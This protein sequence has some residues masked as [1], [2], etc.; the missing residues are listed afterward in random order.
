MFALAISEEPFAFCH[1]C[2]CCNHA[3][4][5]ACGPF[6]RCTAATSNSYKSHYIIT[7]RFSLRTAL[8][9]RASY[10][11]LKLLGRP[12]RAG[13][14]S[15]RKSRLPAR[16]PVIGQSVSPWTVN[17]VLSCAPRIQRSSPQRAEC[18]ATRRA[19][20]QQTHG[21]R[22]GLNW[23]LANGQDAE[24]IQ[25][26]DSKIICVVI[27]PFLF[28]LCIFFNIRSLFERP[29]FICCFVLWYF[30]VLILLQGSKDKKKF[31]DTTEKSRDQD[32]FFFVF[33]LHTCRSVGLLLQTFIHWVNLTQVYVNV[34]VK[35]EYQGFVGIKTNR[36]SVST[37]SW[38]VPCCGTHWQLWSWCCSPK[39]SSRELLWQCACRRSTRVSLPLIFRTRSWRWILMMTCWELP[40]RE[41]R[42]RASHCALVSQFIHART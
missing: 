23:R 14:R 34:S 32:W 27:E 33:C 13:Y 9:V 5:S 16:S 30:L 10:W 12:L 6:S 11:L 19:A 37:P 28:A 17:H 18:G 4:L 8:P 31:S 3:C 38:A 21:S 39:V 22:T 15:N 20:Y 2:P 7:S 40:A 25:W 42:A 29:T 26:N 41:S 24:A 35:E 36:T 1:L